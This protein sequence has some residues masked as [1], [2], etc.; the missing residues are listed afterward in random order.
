MKS[1]SEEED[2]G[3]FSFLYLRFSANATMPLD[4]MQ[5]LKLKAEVFKAMGQPIRLGIVELLLLGEK[6]VSEIADLL[7]TDVT[8]VSKHLTLLR[9]YRMVADRKQGLQTFYRSMIPEVR[10]FLVCVEKAACKASK[11]HDRSE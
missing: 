1:G 5:R 6:R 4:Q 10:D 7:G 2:F 11:A 8:N 3:A 9:K